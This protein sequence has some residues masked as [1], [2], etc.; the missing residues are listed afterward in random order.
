MSICYCGYNSGCV[1][2]SLL[3]ATHPNVWLP[4][5]PFCVE[6]VAGLMNMNSPQ[7]TITVCMGKSSKSMECWLT[8]FVQTDKKCKPVQ[9]KS[10]SRLFIRT[11]VHIS[12]TA[13]KVSDSLFILFSKYDENDCTWG[14]YNVAS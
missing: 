13:Y 2:V 14:H 1:I 3:S 11:V 4:I 7:I 10:E 9:Y 5:T 12:V 8:V 6:E